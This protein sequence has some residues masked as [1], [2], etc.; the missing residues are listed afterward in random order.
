MQEVVSP[1]D[2]RGNA[3]VQ[4]EQQMPSTGQMPEASLASF[5][6][7]RRQELGMDTMLDGIILD[8]VKACREEFWGVAFLAAAR[9]KPKYQ[10]Q[11]GKPQHFFRKVV[12][13]AISTERSRD[14]MFRRRVTAGPL[15]D[16][17]AAKPTS[18]ESVPEQLEHV[19][20]RVS[21]AER[22]LFELVQILGSLAAAGRECGMSAPTACRRL[23]SARA[24][25]QVGIAA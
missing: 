2:G 8:I 11:R 1:R 3:A 6:D 13:N 4:T 14:R 17:H 18:R 12:R 25:V 7:V 19:L 24:R 20:S 23:K 5:D 22:Q 9:A 16:G 10:P 21:P 15:W